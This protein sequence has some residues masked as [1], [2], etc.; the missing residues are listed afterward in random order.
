MEDCDDGIYLLVEE[1][2]RGLGLL[3]MGFYMDGGVFQLEMRSLT[4]RKS[5]ERVS[6]LGLFHQ[7][8]Y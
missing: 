6:A 3:W 7:G 2:E 8:Y 4:A 1:M 5:R